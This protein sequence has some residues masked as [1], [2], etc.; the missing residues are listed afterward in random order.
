MGYMHKFLRLTDLR[1]TALILSSVKI[2]KIPV[3]FIAPKGTHTKAKKHAAKLGIKYSLVEPAT[4]YTSIMK[5][6]S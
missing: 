6:L 1:V 4:A 2:Y 3:V 5:L